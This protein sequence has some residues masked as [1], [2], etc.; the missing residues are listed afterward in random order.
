MNHYALYQVDYKLDELNEMTFN[1]MN[2]NTE[3]IIWN[4]TINLN[5]PKEKYD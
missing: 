5:D 3:R 1:L 2:K 4:V